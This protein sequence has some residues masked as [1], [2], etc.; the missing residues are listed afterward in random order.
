MEIEHNPDDSQR[1]RWSSLIETRVGIWGLGTEGKAAIRELLSH[2][3]RCDLSDQGRCLENWIVAV[4][5]SLSPDTP[6][7]I[8][9]SRNSTNQDCELEILNSPFEALLE[10]DYVIKSPGISLYCDKADQLRTQSIPILSGH[11]LW[12][13]EY[14]DTKQIAPAAQAIP[15]SE[16]STAAGAIT[17]SANAKVG[18]QKG[19]DTTERL[20]KRPKVAVITGS[21]GKSTTTA[22][23][24][25]ILRAQGF[26]SETAGNIGAPAFG[27][28]A[29]HQPDYICLEI[30]SYQSVHL[31]TPGDI[32]ALTSLSPDHLIWHGGVERYYRDKLAPALLPW[33]KPIL[34]ADNASPELIDLLEQLGANYRRVE[35]DA[36][37]ISA[38]AR[39]GLP[40]RHNHYNVAL[41]HQI[42]QELTGTQIDLDQLELQTGQAS[43]PSRLT[44]VT[45]I[46]GVDFYDDCLATNVLPSIVALDAFSTKPT[47]HIV[48]GADR[49]IDYEQLAQSWLNTQRPIHVVAL[50]TP[51]NGKRILQTLSDVAGA[52]RTDLGASANTGAGDLHQVETEST[53]D[54]SVF[55][56]SDLLTSVIVSDL[57]T[58]V[59]SAFQWA[60]AHGAV[61]VLSPAAPSYSTDL[62]GALSGRYPNYIEKAKAYMA[63]ITS[64]ESHEVPPKL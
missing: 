39:L 10:C 18:E 27:R 29:H 14:G 12:L 43:L 15:T 20:S 48:G 22:T 42:A 6:I 26:D 31:E 57:E 9:D 64:L 34:V 11:Q 37:H 4:D 25:T 35:V 17:P 40:G 58:A 33:A 8:T 21:K 5:D 63:A 24:N 7:R 16:S 32:F 44:W 47:V 59:V 55:R 54:N 45:Q 60:K 51:D 50:D 62:N 53:L 28:G 3:R 30:S 1:A 38:A 61:V 46:D 23:T 19:V 52:N 56:H 49:G 13:N 2:T 41:A 36:K